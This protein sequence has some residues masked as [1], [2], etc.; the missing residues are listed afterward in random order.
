M[1]GAILSVPLT[2]SSTIETVL[3]VV[4]AQ[5]VVKAGQSIQAAIDAANDGDTVFVEAGEYKPETTL[6]IDKAINLYGPNWEISGSSDQRKPEANIL[7]DFRDTYDP[8]RISAD[9]VV[10]SGF[11]IQE[12]Q[13]FFIDIQK[14]GIKVSGGFG[15]NTAIRNNI[16]DG[17]FPGYGSIFASG[18]FYN[19]TA[20]VYELSRTNLLIEH[21][22][23]SNGGYLYYQGSSGIIRY[24]TITGTRAGMQ[25]QPYGNVNDTLVEYN[26]IESYILG[27]Y[28]NYAN[29]G[30]GTTTIQHNTITATDIE[31]GN[32]SPNWD[33]IRVQTYATDGTGA[34][35]MLK[36]LNNTIDGADSERNTTGFRTVAN[37]SLSGQYE[38]EDNEFKNVQHGLNIYSLDTFS[39][40]LQFIL[41]NN[42]FPSFSRVIDNTIT[43]PL[44]IN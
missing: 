20:W 5:K 29:K 40:N 31:V 39:G 41:E 37:T 42:T 24:N 18:Q 3:G 10:V 2:E 35:P 26:T 12:N 1:S 28:F 21:N 15:K 27:I 11:K 22:L 33:G 7:L 17:D 9:D 38:I 44:V 30:A 43:V 19:G 8:F 34:D 4:V 14:S 32:P 36:L 25:I 13:E 6:I 16:I 23:L